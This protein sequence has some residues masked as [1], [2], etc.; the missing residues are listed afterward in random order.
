MMEG[1]SHDAVNDRFLGIPAALLSQ[2]REMANTLFTPSSETLV[3]M[4][5]FFDIRPIRNPESLLL[6]SAREAGVFEAVQTVG[7]LGYCVRTPVEE[8]RG[9]ASKWSPR[10]QVF[11]KYV[12]ELLLSK[13]GRLFGTVF[14][15]RMLRSG[16]LLLDHENPPFHLSVISFA[17]NKGFSVLILLA[18]GEFSLALRAARQVWAA[19]A[20]TCL[21]KL[22]Q[23]SRRARVGQPNVRRYSSFLNGW[24]RHI[25]SQG[26]D[27]Q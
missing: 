8:T 14:R 21:A 23:G 7:E 27:P 12:N 18:I 22:G 24:F 6:S 4:K 16:S 9:S 2:A 15:P 13:T 10:R 19:R 17:A 3:E 26:F 11:V 20:Q 1:E 25:L 5:E